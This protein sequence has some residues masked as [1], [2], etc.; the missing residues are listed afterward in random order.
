MAQIDVIATVKDKTNNSTLAFCPIGVKYKNTSILSNEDGVFTFKSLN[1][2]D[3]LIFI[4]I[5]YYKKEVSVKDIIG[6]PKILLTPKQNILNE[7]IVTADN[8]F[9]YELITKARKKILQSAAYQSKAYLTLETEVENQP[10]ELLECYY[11]ANFTQFGI[12][13]LVFKNGRA[14]VAPYNGGY[15]INS[16]TSKVLINSSLVY[17]NNDTPLPYNPLQL[18]EK[19]MRRAYQLQLENSNKNDSTEYLISFTPREKEGEYYKGSIRLNTKTFDIISITL[20][21]DKAERHPFLPLFPDA[22][23]K[24]TKMSITYHFNQ[25][26]LKPLYLSFTFRFDYAKDTLSFSS[27]S[28]GLLYFYDY[29]ATFIPP[30]FD[31]PQDMSDYRRIVSLSYNDLFWSTN[32]GLVY[33]DKMRKGIHYFKNHGRLINYMGKFILADKDSANVFESN[34]MLWD[35]VKRIVAK[36]GFLPQKEFDKKVNERQPTFI[37]NLYQLKVQ[38]FLDA[39][40]SGDTLQTFTKTVLDVH[41][42]FINLPETPELNCFINIYF[43]LYE[44]AR[45]QLEYELKGVKTAD[46][47]DKIYKKI[48]NDITTRQQQ[49]INETQTG[50]NKYYLN[51]WNG[52]V[53]KELNIDNMKIFGVLP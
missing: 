13:D 15:F 6:N 9:L 35:R 51:K 49:F 31:Y 22:K 8:R 25:N 50:K 10:T 38:L 26:D 36:K 24:G 23:I 1:E 48:S 5:G 17:N 11:N 28:K 40:P 30:Y 32:K 33:S 44:I 41:E 27:H 39:N 29:D 12:K 16:G 37:T 19:K 46:K 21:V 14:G 20:Q 2:N 42:T 43:D 7:V 18:T 34:Y 45:R 53:V 47:A 3:T 52:M 4:Y